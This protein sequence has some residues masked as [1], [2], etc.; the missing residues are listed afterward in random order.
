M[1][2]SRL[3]WLI[4]A[5]LLAGCGQI[6]IQRS[7]QA[8]SADLESVSESTQTSMVKT[9][10]PYLENRRSVPAAAKQQFEL[11]NAAIQQGKWSEA[12]AVLK[13]LTS[14]YPELSGPHLNLGIVYLR[15]ERPDELAEQQF[16]RAIA[17][18]PNNLQ[19]YNRLANLKRRQGLFQEAEDYYQ[20]ALEVWPQHPASHLN[21]GI[22]YDL[23]LSDL[24]KAQHHYEMYQSLLPEPDRQVAGWLVDIKRRIKVIAQAA[25]QGATEP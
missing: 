2:Y 16:S 4:L 22:L 12:E 23:Y 25:G 5:V 6:S 7:Q 10:N 19:A 8:P 18:N 17:V 15:T 24:V 11:A 3:S 20:R 14:R 9:P 13:R 1:K 21:I